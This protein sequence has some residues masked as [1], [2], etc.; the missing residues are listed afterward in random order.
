M[1]DEG[2]H[3]KPLPI[4]GHRRISENK[5]RTSGE[6]SPAYGRGL[7]EQF[8]IVMPPDGADGLV[9]VGL[10]FSYRNPAHA[11]ATPGFLPV[12]CPL[13]D[14]GEVAIAGERV[15][16]RSSPSDS[17]DSVNFFF[18][19]SRTCVH[20]T[21][22]P[23]LF[24]VFAIRGE[25]YRDPR[26]LIPGIDN[27][28]AW[29]PNISLPRTALRCRVVTGFVKPR[30]GIATPFSFCGIRPF[31]ESTRV[32]PWTKSQHRWRCRRCTTR[33]T[34][35]ASATASENIMFDRSMPGC[36]VGSTGKSPSCFRPGL[37]NALP[38]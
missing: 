14:H 2:N 17:D 25:E 37:G 21:V 32:G 12:T 26:V 29:E 6:I 15:Q 10:G 11:P 38:S 23:V 27:I 24:N 35:P 8:A 22:W 19:G 28:I 36:V 5:A 20:N 7:V 33:I 13:P 31:G 1:L 18:P 3:V 34:S 9:N 30:S 16:V 4:Y